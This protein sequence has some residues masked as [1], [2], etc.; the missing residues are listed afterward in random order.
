MED[1]FVRLLQRVMPKSNAQ[2]LGEVVVTRVFL[3]NFAGD[4]VPQN[5]PGGSGSLAHVAPRHVQSVIEAAEV[6]P[7]ECIFIEI[8][9]HHPELDEADVATGPATAA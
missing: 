3:E 6:C 9:H 7:G 2:C 1:F 5:D 8:E 4:G